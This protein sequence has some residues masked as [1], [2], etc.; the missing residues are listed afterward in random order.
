M[1]SWIRVRN[2]A[3]I[4]ELQVD[5][6]PG[7]NL[8]TG[9]TGAGNTILIDALSL[10]LGARASGELVRTGAEEASVEAAFQLRDVPQ[11][12]TARLGDAGIDV[13]GGEILIRRE[14]SAGKDDKATRAVKAPKG[15]L[16]A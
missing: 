2:I 12:L 4:E 7:L 9:G 8:L 3:V 15:R 16:A 10:I 14:L 5:F 11:A 1:L 6:G 13:D